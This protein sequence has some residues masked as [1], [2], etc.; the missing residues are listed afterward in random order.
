MPQ[1][2]AEKIGRG[3]FVEMHELLPQEWIHTER[4]GEAPL[5]SCRHKF[6]DV[7]VWAVCFASYISVIA[8]KD[9][10]RV[11]DLLGYP[12]HMT[13]ASLEFERPAW[14]NYDNTFRRQAAV[15]G[16]QNWSSINELFPVFYVLYW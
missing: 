2:L 13:K 3:E 16:N 7:I 5:P 12:V 14:A 8:N 9:P 6:L 10:S 1:K 15:L 11:S 4:E